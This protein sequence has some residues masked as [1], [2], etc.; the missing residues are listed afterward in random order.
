[1]FGFS[2]NQ[3]RP[4]DPTNKINIGKMEDE[5]TG[6]PV[7]KYVGLRSKLH[8]IVTEDW[9]INKA[10]GADVSIEFEK[11]CDVLFDEKMR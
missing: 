1:M 8:P 11:Y 3:S 5:F 6:K 7:W 4:Y 9:E 10:K 2:E